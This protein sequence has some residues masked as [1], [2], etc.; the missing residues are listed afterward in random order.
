VN[1]SAPIALPR[2]TLGFLTEK[3][4]F[5]VSHDASRGPLS[6]V[7]FDFQGDKLCTVGTDGHRFGKAETPL[8]TTANADAG[9]RGVI[10][11]P[12]VLQS[13]LRASEDKD[14]LNESVEILLSETHILFRAGKAWI[15]SKLIEGP[16]PRYEAVIPSEFERSFT[17]N[18]EDFRAVVSRVNTFANP[19]THQV[20]LGIE[21]GSM[22][23]TANGISSSRMRD[24][25]GVSYEGEEPFHIGFNGQYLVE[26][27]GMCS[28]ENIVFKMNQPTSATVICPDGDDQSFFFLLMPLRLSDDE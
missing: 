11:P 3:T 5:A 23:V 22:E 20:R 13:F 4:A 18:R 15:T 14:N 1:D 25:M 21:N 17:A 19:R 16:Y 28:S 10:V 6:G 27:L 2:A 8:D 9:T 26:V 24:R 7:Y 12:E